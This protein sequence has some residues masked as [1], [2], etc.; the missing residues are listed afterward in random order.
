VKVTLAVADLA[1]NALKSFSWTFGVQEP[2]CGQAEFYGIA[3]SSITSAYIVNA[4]TPLADGVM[5]VNAYNP[6]HK[7][8]SW[9][10]NTRIQK[11]D[12]L[13]RKSASIYWLPALDT[14][15]NPAAFFD[16]VCN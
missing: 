8:L 12:L 16:D 4:L 3:T 1:G 9:V 7:E 13:Y 5:S 10:Q 15:G 2:E 11:I 6:K 14:Q